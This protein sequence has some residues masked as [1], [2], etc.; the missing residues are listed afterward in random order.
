MK[1]THFIIP[2]KFPLMPMPITIGWGN[3]YVILPKG[4]KYHGKG[5]FEIPVDVHGGLTYAN[6]SL[7]NI[8]DDVKIKK[9]DWIVGFDTT[10]WGDGPENCD[11]TFVEEETIRLKEQ[12]E[13]ID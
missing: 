6:D 3:G 8:P 13:A 5:Y 7:S 12:L 11:E 2:R 10:H 1:L 9:T 4:H